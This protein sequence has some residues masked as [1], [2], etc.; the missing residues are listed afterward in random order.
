MALSGTPISDY[1][2]AAPVVAGRLVQ[3]GDTEDE[4]QSPG[5]ARDV[6]RRRGFRSMV[7]C[8]LRRDDV[9]IGMLSVT[10][11][12]PGRFTEHQVQLLQTFADQAVIAIENARLFNETQEGLRHQTAVASV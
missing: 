4:A 10:R 5:P 7:L 3:I 12:E 6:A 2:M 1:G 9:S 11:R 8:P